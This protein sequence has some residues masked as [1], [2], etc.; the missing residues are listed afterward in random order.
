MAFAV[1]GYDRIIRNLGMGDVYIYCVIIST[2]P[3]LARDVAGNNYLT[4]SLIGCRLA[5][6]LDGSQTNDDNLV[7]KE[8]E[9]S[10]TS[11]AAGFGGEI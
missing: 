10:R 6:H 2:V 7:V 4:N 8:S 11:Q 1:K 9:Q 3:T 5:D